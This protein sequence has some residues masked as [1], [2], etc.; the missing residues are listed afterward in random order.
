MPTVS[1]TYSSETTIHSTPSDK[2]TKV[3]SI[4]FSNSGEE[5]VTVELKDSFNDVHGNS[6]EKTRLLCVVDAGDTVHFRQVDIDFY[7]DMK[8]VP[9]GAVMATITFEEVD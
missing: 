5:S 9:S 2:I 3:K 1:N 4:L 8:I 7:G 6:V